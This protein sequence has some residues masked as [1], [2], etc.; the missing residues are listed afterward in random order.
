MSFS[1]FSPS[2]RSDLSIVCLFALSTSHLSLELH[3][4]PTSNHSGQRKNVAEERLSLIIL[5]SLR[6]PTPGMCIPLPC[7]IIST[8]L[9]PSLHHLVQ[10]LVSYFV[11]LSPVSFICQLAKEMSVCYD[12]LFNTSSLLCRYSGKHMVIAQEIFVPC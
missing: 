9:C 4:P 10:Y 3:I 5:V 6:P 8:V 7:F 2:E 1:P 11:N 12:S